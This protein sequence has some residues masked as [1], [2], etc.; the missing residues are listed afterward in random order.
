MKQLKHR[1]VWTGCYRGVFFEIVHWDICWNY[2]LYLTV[3][4][5][6]D[7][8]LQKEVLRPEIGRFGYS[9][10][11]KIA[12][13]NALEFHGGITFYDKVAGGKSI[14]IGCD[15]GHFHDSENDYNL[16]D[17]MNDARISIDKLHRACEYFLRNP[18][19]GE[20]M[21]ESEAEYLDE[22][23]CDYKRKQP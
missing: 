7:K 5:L 8:E 22:Y 17:V 4:Q 1:D 14:K 10:Y 21:K 19:N 9:D 11:D 12:L 20:L 23:K 6:S 13:F 18:Y 3:N 15:Y 2:Y 16:E